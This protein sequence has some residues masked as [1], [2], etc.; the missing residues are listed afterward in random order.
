MWKQIYVM[1]VLSYTFT[2]FIKLYQ[3]D[4]LF[5]HM[6]SSWIDAKTEK[7]SIHAV[8]TWLLCHSTKPTEM[9]ILTWTRI[10]LKALSNFLQMWFDIKIYSVF[11]LI[12][13][14]SLS[15]NIYLF[16]VNNRNTRKMCKICS[17]L[18]IKT[19]QQHSWHRSNIFIV[20]L[21]IF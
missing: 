12:L 16:K 10:F 15:A 1:A 5:H 17:K 11:H 14:I 18:T 3:K 7:R 4:L 6:I 20:T 19:L 8:P 21:N 13:K 2:K 9:W